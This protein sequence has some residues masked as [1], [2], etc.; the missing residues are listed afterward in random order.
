MHLLSGQ[1]RQL[2]NMSRQT[3]TAVCSEMGGR[4]KCLDPQEGEEERRSRI[5][6]YARQQLITHG[7]KLEY[8]ANIIGA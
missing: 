3:Y 5:K 7:P 8:M 2:F 6:F 4:R 1:T